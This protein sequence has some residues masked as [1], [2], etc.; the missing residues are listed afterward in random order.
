MI[1]QKPLLLMLPLTIWSWPSDIPYYLVFSYD[2]GKASDGVVALRSQIPH[3]LQK[4][5]TQMHGYSAGHVNVLNG[6][7]FLDDLNDTLENNF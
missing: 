3:F 2:A 1:H 4:Q 5:A 7:R 6:K